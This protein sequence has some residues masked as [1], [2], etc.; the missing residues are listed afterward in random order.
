MAYQVLMS[1]K[2]E[3]E[4]V[5]DMKLLYFL[6]NSYRAGLRKPCISSS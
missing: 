2:R 1:K 5:S 4:G 6:I 3:E